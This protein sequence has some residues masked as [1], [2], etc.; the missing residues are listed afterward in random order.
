MQAIQI[1]KIGSASIA[2]LPAPRPGPE[3]VL[4]KVRSSGLCHTDLDI[5]HG[6]YVGDYPLVPGH[7]FSGIVAETGR[8][9]TIVSEG[10]R[11]A[12]DPLLPCGRCTQCDR[13]KVN[14]CMNFGAYGLTEP[15]AFAPLVAIN[16]LNCHTIGDLP[17]D[18]AALAEPLACVLHGIDRLSPQAGQSAL[19]FGAGP[20]GLMMLIGLMDRGVENVSVV[21]LEDSRLEMASEL[22]A[23]SVTKSAPQQRFDL[24]LDCTGVTSVCQQ[25]PGMT[26]AGGSILF[27]GVCAPDERIR[28]SPAEIF[29]RE[30]TI[31]GSHSLKRNIP[32][33]LRVL[34]LNR[35]AAQRLVTHRISLDEM[36]TQLTCPQKKSRMKT[37]IVFE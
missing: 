28:I 27:F 26:N 14:L 35:A 31:V 18:I 9:V 37:Q 25:L 1:D 33:A 13:G 36:A 3:Q 10:D 7:E 16:A 32:D 5:L 11:V 8:N 29:R 19:I 30:L 2:D 34:G 21:D 20:I 22:G 12:V 23:V 6:R 24:A 15:G 17:F 4:I